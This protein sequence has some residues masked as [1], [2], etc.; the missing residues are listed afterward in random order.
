MRVCF[1]NPQGHLQGHPP[2]GKTDTGGQIVYVLEL[3]RALS[4]QGIKVDLITRQFGGQKPVEDLTSNARI[5]RLP[6]G[7]DTF[8][9]KEHLYELMNQWV[10]RL[11]AF[12]RTEDVQYDII[13]SHY[14]DGGYAGMLLQRRLHIPHVFTPH[15]LGRWKELALSHDAVPG[16]ALAPLYRYQV[17]IMTEK[18]I[19]R[20][21]DVVL[22]LSQ[23]QRVRLMQHYRLDFDKIRVLYPGVDTRV[24]TPNHPAGGN[25]R[26]PTQN[27]ILL[28]SRFVPAKGID[29]AIEVFRRVARRVDCHLYI[30]TTN[31]LDDFSEEEIENERAVRW[32]IE[33]HRLQDRVHFL[34]FIAN[35]RLLADYY[36]STD[37][38]LLPSRYEPFGL[39]TLEALACGAVTLVSHAAGSRELLIDGLN[40]FIVDMEEP[41]AVAKLIVSLFKDRALAQR[42]A[43][44]A[45]LSTQRHFSWDVTAK[46]L[47][48][49]VYPQAALPK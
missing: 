35:R 15:S 33:T 44:N 5:V 21:A 49:H 38:F 25:G 29:T 20:T 40:G 10:Q 24:F 30:V 11:E 3:A 6:C 39:T 14:W 7:P 28:V 32:M 19:M 26:M 48:K 47:L 36:R 31:K 17:R 2:L 9:V 46:R 34:G 41:D 23:I 12:S 18:R 8:V 45:V 42:I 37:L 27:N 1:L 4:R 16:Q 13:H 43:E 22:M